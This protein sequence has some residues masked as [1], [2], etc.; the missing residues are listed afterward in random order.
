MDEQES[1]DIINE[2]IEKKIIVQYI[3][4][5]KRYQEGIGGMF[6]APILDI[7]DEL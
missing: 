2:L 1:E 4:N 3:P 6:K 7:R 5:N